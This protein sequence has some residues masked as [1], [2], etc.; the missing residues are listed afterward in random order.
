MTIEKPAILGGEPIRVKGPPAWP[1]NEESVLTSVQSAL[2]AGSWGRYHGPHCAALER[3]LADFHGCEQALLCSSGTAAIELALRGCGVG[4]GDEVILAAYDFKANF[5]NVLIVGATPVLVDVRKD[6]WQLDHTQLSEAISE[7]TQAIIVSHLHGGVVNLPAVMEFART[8]EISVIE[9]TCQM[10]GAMLFGRRAGMWG[11]V[12]VLS[13]GGSK[14]MTAGR[15]G[16]L[17]SNDQQIMQRI[18][19]Y[20]QRGNRAYPLSELQ[21]AALRPQLAQLEERNQIRQESVQYLIEQ[22]QDITGLQPFGNGEHAA[23][24]IPAYYKVGMQY[25]A[26]AFAGLS[27]EPFSAAVC[28]EGIALHPGFRSLHCIHSQRRFR[29]V[30]DLPIATAADAHVLTLHHPV[31][32]EDRVAMDEI[33]SAIQRVQQFAD[34]IRSHPKTR[35]P[36]Q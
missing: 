10:H 31:L 36:F 22:L 27:A 25:D 5:Q 28:A 24:V 3:E 34:E 1:L 30:G 21:A 29:A 32:L 18:T 2:Q 35:L 15:G 13:F 8:R 12:G 11:D 20:D 4:A 14:L 7:R 33:V 19:L 17:L 16:A 23:E 6:N 26:G 9:D